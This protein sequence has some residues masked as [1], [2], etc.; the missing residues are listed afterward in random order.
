MPG[1]ISAF[2]GSFLPLG[3]EEQYN[4]TLCIL[5]YDVAQ[6]FCQSIALLTLAE[7]CMQRHTTATP[8]SAKTTTY[9]TYHGWSRSSSAR[10][11]EEDS[12]MTGSCGVDDILMGILL[13]APEDLQ[14]AS[15]AISQPSIKLLAQRLTLP[16]TASPSPSTI[17][18]FA[19]C[20]E[21]NTSLIHTMR[22]IY[23]LEMRKHATPPWPTSSYMKKYLISHAV[24]DSW[25]LW[26]YET[27]RQ[28]RPAVPQHVLLRLQSIAIR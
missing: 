10:P 7:C 6:L 23:T 24:L 5:L 28:R 25:A 27:R 14:L 8:W 18:G 26:P 19:T 11:H 12:I 16:A 15:Q 21:I 9:G 1:F 22:P 20:T 3:T 13:A 17:T 4:H 2:R